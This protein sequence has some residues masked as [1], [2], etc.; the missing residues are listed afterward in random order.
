MSED[1][2]DKLIDNRWEKY[3]ETFHTLPVYYFNSLRYPDTYEQAMLLLKG[4]ELDMKN[5][6]AQYEERETE[7]KGLPEEDTEE[8]E[9]EY[10]RWKTKA[11]RA[12]RM[13]FNQIRL[14]EA[15]ALDNPPSYN[16]RFTS[17]EERLGTIE[18]FLGL[19]RD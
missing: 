9:K 16:E 8:A 12:Q 17:I 14:L 15:W 18:I 6:E 19:T 10:K 2:Q 13:K 5:I 7:I 11:L 3:R 1:L 4:I